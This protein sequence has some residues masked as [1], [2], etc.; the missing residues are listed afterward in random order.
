MGHKPSIN[1]RQA[2]LSFSFSCSSF[3]VLHILLNSISNCIRHLF[4][5]VHA[6]LCWLCGLSTA[7]YSV[8]SI[9]SDTDAPSV[10]MSDYPTSSL[11]VF[12]F[13]KKKSWEL[14]KKMQDVMLGTLTE[15][16]ITHCLGIKEFIEYEWRTNLYILPSNINNLIIII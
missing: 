10:M 5:I 14:K 4:R 7:F 12:L 15:E 3:H 16:P 8:F 2:F 11:L 1:S 13:F 6:M 9:I